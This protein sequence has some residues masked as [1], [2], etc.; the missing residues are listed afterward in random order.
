[1]RDCSSKLT[2][3]AK[4]RVLIQKCKMTKNSQNAVALSL[5]EF[6][7]TKAEARHNQPVSIDRAE[8]SSQLPPLTNCKKK[9]PSPL[10]RL[11]IQHEVGA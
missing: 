2:S 5:T 8:L 1:M 11:P 3:S 6:L 10:M 4:G 9:N 7:F